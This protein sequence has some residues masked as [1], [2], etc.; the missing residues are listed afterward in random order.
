MAQT[1]P[2]VLEQ[3]VKQLRPEKLIVVWPGDYRVKQELEDTAEKLNL[4]LEIRSDTHFYC[5]PAEFAEFAEGRKSLLL[6]TFYRQMR[7]KHD[8]LLEDGG[9]VGGDWNLDDQNREAFKSD[10]G[11]ITGPHSFRT[12]AITQSVFDLVEQRYGDHPGELDDFDLPVTR[13]QAR[14]MLRDFVR[15]S[16]PRFGKYEDAMW[17]DQAFVYHSRLSAPL[18]VKLLSARECV[19]KAVEAYESGEAPLNSVEGFVRQI[20]GWREFIRGV[21][22]LQMPAYATRNFL[23]HQ[24][25]V[26]EFFWDGESEMQC[27]KQS[28]QHVIRYGYAHHIHRLMVLGNLA[29]LL[30]VHPYK[31]HEWHMAMYVDAVDWVSLP[32]ALGMSQH[33]DG[34]VVGTKP[35]VSTGNYINKMS[36]FCGGC[37]YNYRE[38]TGEN[39]CPFTTLY[40]D[41][42]DRHY[43]QFKKNHR[44]AM[45]LKQIEK[46]RSSGDM[47]AIR[48]AADKLKQ[49]FRG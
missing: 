32:N 33:G 43:N 35:Y 41:F 7:K 22:W 24:A 47:E 46:K 49:R 8:V 13:S 40:W 30:G 44:M 20:L 26:P 37:Q 17:T 10:P 15:R 39:A 27:V 14:T 4:E 2:S 5:S 21:Y 16:L 45:Q 48:T 19:A 9:P 18:N 36:N 1:L 38:A 3:D 23:H 28:M 34:G 29:L 6:E 25:D 31:F 12:D 42:L 11:R